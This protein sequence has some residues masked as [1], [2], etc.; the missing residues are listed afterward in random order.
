MDLKNI[1]EDIRNVL[2]IKRKEFD[3]TFI[4]DE[5]IYFMKDNDGTIKTDFPS[6][7]SV[8]K[9][10]YEPFDAEGK[11][12]QMVKGDVFEQQ[13]LLKKWKAAGDYSTNLGSRAHFLLE[14]ESVRRNGEYKNVREPIFECDSSQ[15][16]K[17]DNM[18]VAGFKFLDLMEERGGVLLDTEMVLGHPELRYTGQPDKTWLIMNKP[19]TE[20]GIVITDWKTN[21]P[22]N[23]EVMPYTK[24]MYP[25]F[26]NYPSTALGHYYIQLPLYG[27]LLLKMLE[28]TKYENLKIY[29]CI[30]VL[31]LENGNFVEYRVPTDIT[32]TILNMNIENYLK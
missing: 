15:I 26:D 9:L 6:V 17:S 4:E 3:L 10:F 18:I 5:H 1:S 7:S 23:F 12:L 21:Q 8:I 11:S 30:V 28:G 2:E 20:F 16:I 24:M 22:K 32:T 19:K 31:L 25:P 29:G 27:K 14:T 13:E